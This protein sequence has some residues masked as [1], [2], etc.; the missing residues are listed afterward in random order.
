MPSM[1]RLNRRLARWQRHARRYRPGR[2]PRNHNVRR[3]DVR[4]PRGFI[5]A[6]KAWWDERERRFWD[7]TPEIWLGG[8][9]GEAALIADVLCCE[10]GCP[11]GDEPDDDAG[12]GDSWIREDY[13]WD[14]ARAARPVETVD[15]GGLT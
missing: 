14:S 8:P 12:R 10:P 3:C 13:A 7:E 9:E 2:W 15:T 6:Y 11:C 5:R 1:R 4:D